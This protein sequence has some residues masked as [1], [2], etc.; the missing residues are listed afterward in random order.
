M[1]LWSQ[2]IGLGGQHFSSSQTLLFRMINVKKIK[3][4]D[5]NVEIF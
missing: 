3:L 1:G 2:K 4:D 5:G